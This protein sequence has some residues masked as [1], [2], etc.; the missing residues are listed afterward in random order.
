[1][2]K[3]MTFFTIVCLSIFVV[4]CGEATEDTGDT[5]MGG[6]GELPDTDDDGDDED[7]DDEDGDDDGGDDDG[8]DDKG[9]DDKGA[10]DK[11][12]DDKGSGEDGDA[13]KD[14]GDK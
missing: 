3:L 8:G 1:M 7:G 13:A 5:D 4:G 12:A 2:K 14:G 9:A 10:D 6:A 11:G